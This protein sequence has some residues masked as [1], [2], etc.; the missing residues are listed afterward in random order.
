M[1]T[2]IL[3]LQKTYT[4]DIRLESL[5]DGPGLLPFKLGPTRIISHY[6][7]FI[8]D[9]NLSDLQEK[10]VLVRQ[11][12]NDIMPELNNKTSRLYEPHINYLKYKI[13]S[14]FDQLQTFKTNRVKRGL[15]DGLG[16]VIK[17]IT[18]N[19]DY[20]D[21]QRYDSA[22]KLIQDN[23]SKLATELNNH[24]SFSK[25]WTIQYT[26]IID[27]MLE[28]QGKMEVL[29]E[30]IRETEITKDYD[31]IKYAHLAQVF[32]ILGDNVDSISQELLKLQD[33]LAL[34]KLSSLHH[35][36]LSINSIKEMLNR[37]ELLYGRNRI[38]NLDIREY[39]DVI[40]IGSYYSEN[41]IVIVYR[42]PI[43]LE[44]I[45]E[46]Y[47]LCIV[48]NKNS[49]I[50][51]P[52]YPFLAIHQKDL[53]YIEAECPKTNKWYLCEEEWNLRNQTTHDCIQQLLITQQ[54]LDS[55]S[56]HQAYVSLEKPA[57][58][59]LDDLHYTIVFPSPTKTHLSCE[60]DLYRILQG[61]YLAI[62]PHDCFM[63]TSEFKISN[64]EDHLKGQA[65]KIMNLP[66]DTT[67]SSLE[68]PSLKL[69]TVNLEHLQ[70]AN[71]RLSHQEIVTMKQGENSIYHTTIP[72][73]TII[74]IATGIIII[75]IAHRR[76]HQR[77][78]LSI[79]QAEKQ[80]NYEYIVENRNIDPNHLPAQFTTKVSNRRC[81]TGGGVTVP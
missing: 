71:L 19:L 48:P 10:I 41:N 50:L 42:F 1:T 8:Q 32:L 59:K 54:K 65:V 45:Y 80:D 76:L 63:E 17:S 7:S 6:H 61:S 77:K 78:N 13:E 18:G 81:S 37:L 69:N 24:I 21:A 58:E 38:I 15:I 44:D 52:P 14:I 11:Q 31:L 29:L 68:L 70:A 27:N 62:I 47:K 67:T 40:K 55:C 9:I 2:L 34:I 79:K 5:D 49:Q 72:V 56:S 26:K 3:L 74:L 46:M 36:I 12:L 57:L 22:L 16:S 66:E 43:V 20:T 73:Y 25:D 75:I 64:T 53:R 28:S 4:Q 23:E 30:K 39:Y 60:Q 51:I 35:S 33:A